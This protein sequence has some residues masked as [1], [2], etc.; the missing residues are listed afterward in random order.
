MTPMQ[1]ILIVEDE[2]A[3]ANLIKINLTAEGYQC[4]CAYD[5]REGADYI[6]NETYGFLK[7]E[8]RGGCLATSCGVVH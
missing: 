1:R 5:G 2:E 6:E 7:K 4:T 3:I 8:A